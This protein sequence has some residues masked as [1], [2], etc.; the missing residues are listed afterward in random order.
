MSIVRRP[1]AAPPTRPASTAPSAA[2]MA[3]LCSV[4]RRFLKSQGL[5]YTGE[6]AE[7]LEAIIRRDGLFEV[8]ELVLDLRRGGHDVSK[9]TVYRTINLLIQAGLIVQALFDSKQAHYQLIYGQEPRDHMVCMR[10]GRLVEF[11]SEE[12]SA[13][14][15]R[16]CRDLGWDPI[17][18]RFQIYALSPEGKASI[19]AEAAGDE[20]EE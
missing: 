14:R 2:P 9:A 1:L 20:R 13:L 6:R 11:E 3:P 17:A 8:E 10:T 18:H 15:D 7:V 5:K 4:F 12:L 19:E 16:I